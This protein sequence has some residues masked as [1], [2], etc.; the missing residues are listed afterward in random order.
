ML[1]EEQGCLKQNWDCW[2]FVEEKIYVGAL[3]A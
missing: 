3:F 2:V 1:L